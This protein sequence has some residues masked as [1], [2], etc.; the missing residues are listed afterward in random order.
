[1]ECGDHHGESI[2][3]RGVGSLRLGIMIDKKRLKRGG[4]MKKVDQT[5]LHVPPFHNGNCMNAAF[6]SILEIDIEDIPCF[7]DMPSHGEGKK[8]A[9]SWFP[10]LL[11]WLGAKGYY[12]PAKFANKVAAICT[13]FWNQVVEPKEGE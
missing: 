1:M 7:E 9:Q 2:N 8:G 12:L 11:D 6:A 5:K 10:A 4:I 13:A 3:A